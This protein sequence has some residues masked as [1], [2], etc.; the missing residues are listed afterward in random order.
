MT[1]QQAIE[2]LCGLQWFGANFGLERARRLAELAGRPHGRLRFIHVAGSNGKGSVCALLESVYRAAG[3]RTGLYTSPHLVS[4][5]ERL[6][7]NREV[8]GEAE[9]ID[10]TRRAKDWLADGMRR[11]WWEA[12]PPPGAAPGRVPDHPTFFEV[13]TVMALVHFAEQACDI[14][15]WETGLGGRLDATNIVTPLAAVITNIAL[16]HM[17]Y[18][19]DT[20]AKIAAEKSGIIKPGIPVITGATDADAMRVIGEV[21]ASRKAPLICVGGNLT[22]E[23]TPYERLCE[24]LFAGSY[25]RNNAHVALATIAELQGWLPVTANEIEHGLRSFYWPGRLQ[26]CQIGA[27]RFLID[28]AHNPAGMRALREALAARAEWQPMPVILGALADK[29][30]VGLLRELL[31]LASRLVIVPVASARTA[32]PGRLLAV[33]ERLQPGL[34]MEIRA[35][36]RDA[37]DRTANEPATLLTGSLFLVGEFLTMLGAGTLN[38]GRGE[39]GLNDW[40]QTGGITTV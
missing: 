28:G 6:Q 33:A 22:R 21:A 18:L 8:A 24:Q 25:Q 34:P 20:F 1:Y 7:V 19:G 13:V 5:R 16:E 39:L 35:S 23:R 30:E 17:Q 26:E 3:R 12:T 4:F 10:L 27:R 29:D 14:V 40:A 2:F 31:P 36:L 11:G 15:I 37:L 32:E 38:S 9:V